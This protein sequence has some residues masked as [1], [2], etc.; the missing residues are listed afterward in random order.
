MTTYAF[1]TTDS[2]RI[3]ASGSNI[4]QAF[5]KAKKDALKH[6]KRLTA[7]Y[8]TYP[9]RTGIDTGWKSSETLRKKVAADVRRGDRAVSEGIKVKL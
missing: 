8:T 4:I 1:L 9:N 6:G 2:W 3:E 7:S 5:N